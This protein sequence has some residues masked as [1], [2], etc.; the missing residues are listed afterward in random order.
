MN[1]RAPV[2]EKLFIWLPVHIFPECLSVCVC[3]SFPFSYEAGKRDLILLVP[4]Y[5]LS[6]HFS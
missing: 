3:A 5:C 6:F 1:E 4:D 2:W